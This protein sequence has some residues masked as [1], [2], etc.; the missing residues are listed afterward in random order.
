MQCRQCNHENVASNRFCTQC[1]TTLAGSGSLTNPTDEFE[2]TRRQLEQQLDASKAA[3]D[4]QLRHFTSHVSSVPVAFSPSVA[5]PLVHP[6]EWAAL[7]EPQPEQINQSA[8]FVLASPFIQGNE[9]YRERTARISFAFVGDELDVNAFATDQA[10]RS[11][12]GQEIEPPAIVFLGGLATAVRL[13]SAALA[14]H[15]QSK[16]SFRVVSLGADLRDAFHAMGTA[17]IESGGQF[18]QERSIGIFSQM[19]LPVLSGSHEGFISLARSLSA[20]MDMFV[21]AHEA[22]H[23]ALAHTLGKQHNYDVSRNQEREADSFASSS[24]STSPFR[25]Y[26]FVGQVFVALVFAWVDEAARHGKPETHP[27]GRERV[28]NALTSNSEAAQ[29]AAE[30]FGLTR[31]RL[32][33]LL[34]SEDRHGFGRAR[35]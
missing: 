12:R 28:L 14:A 29:E 17:M 26:L 24:L 16:D 11:P 8:Q 33:E 15:I 13:A 25:E 20:S 3:L 27:L 30:R 21:V 1:G 19:V 4:A 7:L 5:L 18:S 32:A 2:R 10:L 31:E 35:F 22:G 23:I 6:Q 34:P 9:H